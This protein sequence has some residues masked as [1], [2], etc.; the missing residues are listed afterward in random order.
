[1]DWR[2]FWDQQAAVH[3]DPHAQVARMRE[4]KASKQADLE[5]IAAY[6]R[7][8]L[9]LTEQDKVLD[10]CCGN[11]GL[12][13][14]LAQYC[15][16]VTAVDFSAPHLEIARQKF[17]RE[18]ITHVQA[19]AR[20]L[21][22]LADRNFDKIN[23]YFSFQYFDT[24]EIGQEVMIQLA[25][26]LVPGGKILIGDVPDAAKIN[27][28]YSSFLQR[29]RYRLA[30]FRGRDQ[31]GKF[32]KESEMKQIAAQAG[33]SIQQLQQPPDFLYQHYRVDYL[34]GR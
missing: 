6:I 28:F 14:V 19:D 5:E 31:M 29:L 18:N 20:D 17:P 22:I 21:S 3:E 15:G 33:L 4:G 12:S 1:M 9:T 13:Q 11:G 26:R 30:R 7:E 8:K 32:W 23:L 16:H 24:L 10:L 27:I 2:A 34:L 25:Q